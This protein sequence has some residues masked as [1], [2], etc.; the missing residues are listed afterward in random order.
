M[1]APSAKALRGLW[2]A[3]NVAEATPAGGDFTEARLGDVQAAIEWLQTELQ[4]PHGRGICKR[5]G[6]PARFHGALSEPEVGID[7]PSCAEDDCEC[8]EYQS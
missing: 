8:E 4:R 2:A 3:L 1:R 6:H 7:D 5:C